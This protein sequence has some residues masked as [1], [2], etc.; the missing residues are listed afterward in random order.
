MFGMPSIALPAHTKCRVLA[1]RDAAAWIQRYLT[2][3]NGGP[4][5]VSHGGRPQAVL[6]KFWR[7]QVKLLVISPNILSKKKFNVA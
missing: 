7:R 2:K 1:W 4:N 3:A 5:M 6:Q